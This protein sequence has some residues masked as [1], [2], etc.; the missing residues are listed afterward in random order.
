MGNQA[1]LQTTAR[2][3]RLWGWFVCL[4]AH[5]AGV[6]H[7]SWGWW[8]WGLQ[9]LS[10]D[11]AC[12]FHEV[13]AEGGTEHGRMDVLTLLRTRGAASRTHFV[14]D[15]GCERKHTVMQAASRHLSYVRF[16]HSQYTPRKP[17]V[18][19]PPPKTT[20]D[21]TF[22][23]DHDNDTSTTGQTARPADRILIGQ[24]SGDR[25]PTRASR[26]VAGGRAGGTES[27]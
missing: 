14:I 5:H 1:T 9:R 2:V 11:C 15:A 13:I 18:T 19:L 23:A 10:G 16:R 27:P 17:T 12:V 3:Y 26:C 7:L 25:H 20:W 4:V 22:L 6:L 8:R 21:S 24:R